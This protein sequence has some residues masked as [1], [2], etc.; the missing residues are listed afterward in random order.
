MKK[1]VSVLQRVWDK[2]HDQN[3]EPQLRGQIIGVKS[4]MGTF[5]YFYG[6]SVLEFVLR[7][8]SNLSRTLENPSINACQRKE[9]ANLMLVPLK[10]L[11]S[12]DIFD[13]M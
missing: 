2:S 9:V 11:I 10:S 13:L 7:H 8:N 12:D 6:F 3:L 1:S 5:S 4:H